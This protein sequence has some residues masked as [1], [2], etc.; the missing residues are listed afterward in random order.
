MRHHACAKATFR[1]Q[2]YI[3][4]LTLVIRKSRSARLLLNGVSARL[5]KRR[6][7]FLCAWRRLRRLCASDLAAG[8]PLAFLVR[9][10]LRHLLPALLQDVPVASR[11]A[12]VVAHGEPPV[13]PSH[14][15]LPPGAMSSSLRILSAHGQTLLSVTA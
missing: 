3:F 4:C 6:T 12:P 2:P 7:F 15:L 13:R 14:D 8:P 11:E 9:R 1:K 10:D 5:V